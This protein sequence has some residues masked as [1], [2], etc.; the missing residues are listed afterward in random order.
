MKKDTG[1]PLQ[2]I[3][4][5]QGDRVIIDTPNGRV[6]IDTIHQFFYY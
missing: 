3:K 4:T 6:A 5:F 2:P 1:K